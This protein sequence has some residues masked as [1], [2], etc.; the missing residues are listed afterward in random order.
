[1]CPSDQS[2]NYSRDQLRLDKTHR[3]DITFIMCNTTIY[4]PTNLA[5]FVNICR[6]NSIQCEISQYLCLFVYCVFVITSGINANDYRFR[7]INS[8]LPSDAIWRERVNIGL[9]YGL[10]PVKALGHYLNHWLFILK[11]ILWHSPGS[12]FKGGSKNTKL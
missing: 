8:L 3:P 7:A 2:M 5:H 9:G 12:Q 6:N 4:T 11:V 10:L 1:M